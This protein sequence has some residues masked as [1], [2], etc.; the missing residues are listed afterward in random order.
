MPHSLM[1]GIV[2]LNVFIGAPTENRNH[3][4][5]YGFQSTIH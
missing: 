2:E 4:Y 5:G 1:N 3:G